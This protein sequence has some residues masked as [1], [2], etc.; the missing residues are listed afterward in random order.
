M[1]SKYINGYVIP[2]V[3]PI[4][5]LDL[6]PDK[7]GELILMGLTNYPSPTEDIFAKEDKK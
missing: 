1:K 6:Y 2:K 3:K 7:I 5:L 4:T